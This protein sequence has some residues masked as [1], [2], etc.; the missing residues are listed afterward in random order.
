MLL[1]HVSAV[2]FKLT[3]GKCPQEEGQQPTRSALLQ[4]SDMLKPTAAPI[5][6]LYSKIN[7]RISSTQLETY[8]ALWELASKKLTGRQCGYITPQ[9]TEAARKLWCKLKF[10]SSLLDC[11]AGQKGKKELFIYLGQPPAVPR[12]AGAAPMCP[13]TALQCSAQHCC[14]TTGRSH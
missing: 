6:N 2:N 3:A 10:Y 7:V 4:S 5:F 12:G 8:P 13:G 14:R 11:T 1:K 9:T